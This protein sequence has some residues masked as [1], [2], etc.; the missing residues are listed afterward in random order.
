MTAQILVENVTKTYR[1]GRV[2]ALDGVTLRVGAGTVLGVI[3]PNGAGKSTLM[4]CLLG[5][6]RPDS[7]RVSIGGDPPDALRARA[8]TGYLPERLVF[9]RWMLGRDFLAY[10]HALAG[11]TRG[12]RASAVAAALSRAGLS[13]EEAARPLK[14]Y[15]R[16]MLQRLGLA[17]SFIGS[18]TYLLL[19]EPTSRRAAG[20][21]LQERRALGPPCS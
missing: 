2:R 17:Q 9:D 18:P 14:T 15:S 1:R 19:D 20:P 8:A 16:G 4:G 12:D 3:G 6:L 21:S 13:P 11:G 10:Q 5:L 7:G